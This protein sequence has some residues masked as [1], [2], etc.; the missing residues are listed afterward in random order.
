[1]VDE[2]VDT[3]L[4]LVRTGRLTEAQIDQSVARVDSLRPQG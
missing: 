4:G 3:V 2:T 1:V